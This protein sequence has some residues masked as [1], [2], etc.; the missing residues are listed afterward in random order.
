MHYL[1]I[2]FFEIYPYLCGTVFI[3]GSWLRYDY[4]Q[5]TAR[6]IEPDAG[7]RQF[8]PRLESVPYRHYRHLLRPS[9]RAVDAALGV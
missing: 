1:N 3:I 9:V 2:F 8:P 6:R 7:Q 5:Y 4:G